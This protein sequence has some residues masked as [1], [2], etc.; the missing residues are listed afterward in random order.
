MNVFDCI[1]KR[2]SV[3]EFSKKPVDDKLIGVMLHMATHA[4]SAGNVQEWRF[5]VVK[6]EEQKRK[7]SSAALRQDF[8]HEAPVVIVVCAD[9][10]RA[11]LRYGKRGETFYAIQDTANATML[12]LLTAEGLGLSTCWVGAFDED[13]VKMALELPENLRPIAIVPVGYTLEVPE[14]PERLTFN[15]LTSVDKHDKKYDI[16]YF[17]QPAPKGKVEIK[18]IG[19]VIEDFLREHIKKTK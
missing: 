11:S 18:P 8:V 10:E 6:D 17:T 1:M 15:N 2:R 5:V 19:N 14:T 9:L 13:A 12:I 3:R 16:S 7:L 4:P